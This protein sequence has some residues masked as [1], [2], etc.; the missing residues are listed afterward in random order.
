MLLKNR[1]KNVK[2][3]NAQY[4]T[5]HCVSMQGKTTTLDQC[6]NHWTQSSS[7]VGSVVQVSRSVFSTRDH[8]LL[9]S[10]LVLVSILCG[11]GLRPWQSFYLAIFDIKSSNYFSLYIAQFYLLSFITINSYTCSRQHS[12]NSDQNY[13]IILLRNY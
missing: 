11:V 5:H 12:N 3:K 2:N 7:Q 10:V 9:V 1:A 13:R 6:L 4:N 8:F